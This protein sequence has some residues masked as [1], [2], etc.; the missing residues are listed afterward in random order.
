MTKIEL[1][2]MINKW[3]SVIRLAVIAIIIEMVFA[4]IIIVFGANY[5]F[6]VFGYIAIVVS[7]IGIG[8]DIYSIGKSENRIGKLSILYSLHEEDC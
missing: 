5:G 2:E 7:V 8:Y 6:G 1:L 4:G 3:E